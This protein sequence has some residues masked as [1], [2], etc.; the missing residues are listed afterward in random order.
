MQDSR[1]L[2]D[3]KLGLTPNGERQGPSLIDPP[4]V[5]LTQPPFTW[6]FL[7][8]CNSEAREKD[9]L[10]FDGCPRLPPLECLISG[11]VCSGHPF[12]FFSR[13]LAVL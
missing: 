3:N 7:S 6:A 1:N 13:S 9:L 12:S 11:D 4:P 10:P 2:E 8:H 5:Y